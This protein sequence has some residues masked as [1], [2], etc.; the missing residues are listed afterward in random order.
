M[1]GKKHTTEDKITDRKLDFAGDR[2]GRDFK[3]EYVLDPHSYP[4]QIFSQLDFEPS[5][6]NGERR[7]PPARAVHKSQPALHQCRRSLQKRARC[8]HQQVE[9]LL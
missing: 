2:A 9:L 7:V 5:R 4:D 6:K 3:G 8:K 1:N